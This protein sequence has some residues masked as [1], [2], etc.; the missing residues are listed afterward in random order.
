MD[1]IKQG[2]VREKAVLC[3]EAQPSFRSQKISELLTCRKMFCWKCNSGT[4]CSFSLESSSH[5]TGHRKSN[6]MKS[7]TGNLYCFSLQVDGYLRSKLVPVHWNLEIILMTAHC[8]GQFRCTTGLCVKRAKSRS[9][10]VILGGVGKQ[11]YSPIIL[12]LFNI[13]K[14]F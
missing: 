10:L 14:R 5:H 7:G 2:M 11:I 4:H 3:M 1:K 9:T 12:F 6:T 13:N 8:L